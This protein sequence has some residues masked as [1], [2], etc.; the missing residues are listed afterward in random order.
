MEAV[1]AFLLGTP[2]GLAILGA[3]VMGIFGAVFALL[4]ALN[5]QFVIFARKTPNKI[6]DAF[7]AAFA[8]ALEQGEDVALDLARK[9]IEK[10]KRD[11]E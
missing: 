4:R 2:A 10:R 8:E 6:D 1:L 7:A 3:V 11:A 5:K 9:E